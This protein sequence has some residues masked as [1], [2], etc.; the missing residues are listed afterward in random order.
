MARPAE[1]RQIARKWLEFHAAAY[2]ETEDPI[3]AWSAYLECRAARLAFPAWLLAYSDRTARKMR[4]LDRETVRNAKDL[5]PFVADA[6]GMIKRRSRKAGRGTFLSTRE[7]ARRDAR[8]AIRVSALVSNGI[9]ESKAIYRVAT[10]QDGLGLKPIHASQS[11]VRRAWKRF[12]D[13]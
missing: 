6:V 2:A 11:T 4:A 3:A 9:D 10:Q 13:E 1:K 12:P 5:S 7:Q 8:L